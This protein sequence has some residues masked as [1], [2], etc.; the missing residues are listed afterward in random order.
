MTANHDGVTDDRQ[1]SWARLLPWV[2]LVLL[3][4]A[5]AIWAQRFLADGAGTG[6]TVVEVGECDLSERA[7]TVLLPSG[8]AARLDLAPRPVVLLEPL[9][10]ELELSGRDPS[11]VDVDLAGVEM[12]MGFNRP[13]LERVSPGV[14]RGEVILPTCSS[15]RMTWAATVLPDGDRARA[16]VQFQ[17]STRR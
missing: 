16:E 14:Y 12:F 15:N 11:W 2:V 7:C 1:G 4:V 5:L 8:G 13:R 6:L 3:V 10:L 9:I 17:F